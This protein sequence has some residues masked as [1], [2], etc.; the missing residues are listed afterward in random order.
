MF[1][2][3]A[4]MKTEAGKT[5]NYWISNVFALLGCYVALIGD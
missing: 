4:K 1:L 3:L 5:N 2:N